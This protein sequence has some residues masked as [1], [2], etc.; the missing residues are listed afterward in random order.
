MQI[1]KSKGTISNNASVEQKKINSDQYISEK[2]MREQINKTNTGGTYNHLF[3]MA[4]NKTKYI[5]F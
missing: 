4:V 5:I 2:A 1:T 3:L